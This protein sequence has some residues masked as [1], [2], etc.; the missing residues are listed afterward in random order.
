M[1]NKRFNF[2]AGGALACLLVF[3]MHT[4]TVS[5]Q[6]RGG[7]HG[8]GGGAGRGGGMG[9]SGMGGSPSNPGI[10]GVDRGIGTASDR[11]GG[12]SDAGRGRASDNSDGRS[13]TGTDRARAG[14]NN[15]N[16]ENRTHDTDASGDSSRRLTGVARKLNTTPEALQSQYEAARTANPNLKFGQFIAA[17]VLASNLSATHSNVTTSAI[18]S[19]LQKNQSIGQTLQSLGVSKDEARAAEK[20]AKRKLKGS[21]N[22]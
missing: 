9:N 12:R 16:T 10:G 5:A 11:S 18:L 15:R 7:G 2:L 14:R 20:D 21:G 22:N 8:G 19:G 6:G 17:N 3:G 13:G 4:T 1:T